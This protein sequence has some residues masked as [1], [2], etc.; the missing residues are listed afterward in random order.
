MRPASA[1]ITVLGPGSDPYHAEHI[2]VDLVERA[3]RYR[4]RQWDVGD[5]VAEER[6]AHARDMTH[7]DQTVGVRGLKLRNPCAS[8]VFE[9]S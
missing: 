4:M 7:R 3:H 8:Y 9:I 2:H 6:L 5:A 1:L